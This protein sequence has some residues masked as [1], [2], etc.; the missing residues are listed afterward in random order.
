MYQPNHGHKNASAVICSMTPLA[1]LLRPA[2][3]TMLETALTF[4]ATGNFQAVLL[5][6]R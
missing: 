4:G 6:L 2:P 1:L 5:G 3:L